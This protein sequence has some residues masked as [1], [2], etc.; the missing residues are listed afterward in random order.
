MVKAYRDTAAI[1]ANADN[2][3]L[4]DQARVVQGIVP[5]HADKVARLDGKY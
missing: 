3:E 1:A 5:T 2:V 4:V